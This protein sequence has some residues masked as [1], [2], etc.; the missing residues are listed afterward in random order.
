MPASYGV[1]R[2]LL[3]FLIVAQH[4]FISWSLNQL[5]TRLIF[6]IFYEVTFYVLKKNYLR[7]KLSSREYYF[8]RHNNKRRRFLFWVWK[9]GYD[10]LSNAVYKILLIFSMGR[11]YFYAVRIFKIKYTVPCHDRFFSFLFEDKKTTILALLTQDVIWIQRF[12][13]FWTL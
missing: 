7:V 9:K 13:V 6:S 5:L 2:G 8:Y 4:L 12:N 3:N 10:F 11:I 1:E